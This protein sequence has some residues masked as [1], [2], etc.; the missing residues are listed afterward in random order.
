M[1]IG[2]D[3]K[4]GQAPRLVNTMS[5]KPG[6]APT[7]GPV[8]RYTGAPQI[9]DNAV[10]DAA[11][12]R[13]AQAAGARREAVGEMTRA[14]ISRGKGHEYAGDIAD[15]AALADARSDVAK[16]ELGVSQQNAAA[17]QSYDN[18]KKNERLSNDGLLEQLRSNDVS[19]RLARQGWGLDAY[20]AL[21]RGQFGLDQMRLDMSPLWKRLF[22]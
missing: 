12:N 21:R 5:P 1:A 9:N 15:E 8:Q 2:A 4:V 7:G 13:L 6:S 11:N 18:M 22:S 19:E 10:A 3:Y 17:R 20:E 14:G 16:M